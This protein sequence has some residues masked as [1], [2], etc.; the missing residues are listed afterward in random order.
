MVGQRVLA[1]H[2]D[3]GDLKSGNI[4]TLDPSSYHV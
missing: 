4:L 3:T 1:I 2:P